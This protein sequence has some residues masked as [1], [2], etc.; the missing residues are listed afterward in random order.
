MNLSHP[1][2]GSIAYTQTGNGSHALVL[3]HGFCESSEIWQPILPYLTDSYTVVCIDIGSFGSSVLLGETTIERMAAQA[4]AVMQALGQPTYTVMGHSLGG[5]VALAML[6]QYAPQVAGIGL[7]HAHPYA[8][9]PE[10]KAN[11]TKSMAFVARNGTAA[12]VRQLFYAL[13][14]PD[15]ARANTAFIEALAMAA[16]AIAP[17]TIIAT[18]QAMRDRPDRSALLA[19]AQ[20]PVLLVCGKQDNTIPLEQNLAQSLL[21]SVVKLALLP[22][23]GHV[24]MHE[25]P[26]EVAQAMRSYLSFLLT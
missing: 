3:L 18:S 17:Q 20:I 23:V 8:D 25:A 9:S 4:E 11:R 1:D 14:A 24:G 13:F 16:Q 22:E 12:F 2:L 5:Y 19:Q 15:F 26:A 6:A 21:P 10:K 7:I